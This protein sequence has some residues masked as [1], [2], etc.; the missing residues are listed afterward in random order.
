LFD[1]GEIVFPDDRGGISERQLARN[2]RMGSEA[3]SE[4]QAGED[5]GKSGEF[6]RSGLIRHWTDSLT[7]S[8]L[9]GPGWNEKAKMGAV[10]L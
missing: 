5:E 6:H 7:K 9:Q 2:G 1:A 3:G 8:Q 10:G 4:D